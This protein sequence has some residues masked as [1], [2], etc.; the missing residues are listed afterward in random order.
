[1]NLPTFIGFL[2]L[3]LTSILLIKTPIVS[4]QNGVICHK[5]NG[6]VIGGVSLSKL[7]QER[8]CLCNLLKEGQ[9]SQTPG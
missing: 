8:H 5:A 6:C 4:L 9:L 2:A 7:E 1:M 3:A